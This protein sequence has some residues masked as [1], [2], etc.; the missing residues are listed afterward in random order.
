MQT[1][2]LRILIQ[3]YQDGTVSADET[4][5]L[6]TLI[7]AEWQQ[8]PMGASMDSIDWERMYQQIRQQAGMADQIPVRR[9]IV[10]RM[11]WVA[12]VA[13]IILLS[14]GSYYWFF[15]PKPSTIVKP[16]VAQTIIGPGREGAILTLADGKRVVLDSL[17]NGAIAQQGSTRIVKKD[18][19]LQ[20]ET[21]DATDGTI[22][23]NTMTTPRGRQYQLLL[24]D[25]TQVWLN[26]A[27]S[28]TYP[29]VF[30]GKE[31][32]VSITGEA[33]FEVAKNAQMPFVVDAAGKVNVEVL[34][35]HFNVNAYADEPDL[36]T[37]L[38]EGKVRLTLSN[39]RIAE[40]LP[41][42]TLA[43]GEQGQ[44]IGNMLS[45]VKDAD[46]SKVMAWK[47][48]LFNFDDASLAV[49]MRQLER[50]YDIDVRYEGAVPNLEFS[51]KLSKNMN[52]QD[53][54]ETLKMTHV[55]FRLEEGRR[56]VVL[57]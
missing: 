52:L 49:V 22:A 53:L 10:Y 31:R 19:N 56:L 24:P 4:S 48:G 16:V 33:Y 29:T 3:R 46:V 32:R 41:S 1:D 50:W 44:A 54:L 23:Y 21:S 20:Y 34:G 42:K 6:E 55:H 2:R 9:G 12:T 39:N 11:R 45:V 17:H 8:L 5:E 13:A 57:P 35:T 43:P 36:R 47:N 7:A 15:T 27:S 51:G 40:P 26:A 30:A 38:L 18:G 25:G 28:I 37:T 14:L